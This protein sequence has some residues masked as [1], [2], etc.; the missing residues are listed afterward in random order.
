MSD[1]EISLI[2]MLGLQAGALIG[3]KLYDWVTYD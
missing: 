3:M 2:V 1:T